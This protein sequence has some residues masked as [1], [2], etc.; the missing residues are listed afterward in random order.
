M[1]FCFSEVTA[2][3]D[4]RFG[5]VRYRNSAY[6]NVSCFGNETR[7]VDCPRDNSGQSP[8]CSFSGVV[9]GASEFHDIINVVLGMYI[10]V[11][12]VC[13][14]RNHWVNALV[15]GQIDCPPAK[16]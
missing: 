15:Q 10:Y 8:L 7:L 6:Q 16:H 14:T 4:D 11:L 1:Y 9:C 3:T 13:S 2:V 12:S 5:S